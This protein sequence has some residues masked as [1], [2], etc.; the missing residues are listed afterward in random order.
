MELAKAPSNLL[1]EIKS[2][3]EG[4]GWQKQLESMGIRKGER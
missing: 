4:L 3:A 2:F 1:L